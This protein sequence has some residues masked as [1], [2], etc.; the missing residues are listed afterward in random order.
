MRVCDVNL[1][2]S[3]GNY[4][5]F[6]VPVGCVKTCHYGPVILV[7]VSDVYNLAIALA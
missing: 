6:E 4:V 5:R 2:K 1:E 3:N 7:N